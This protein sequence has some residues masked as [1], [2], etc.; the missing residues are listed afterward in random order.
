M[1]TYVGVY[2]PRRSLM[3]DNGLP[4]Y[5][6][7]AL[8][9]IV[10]A[11]QLVGKPV[12]YEHRGIEDACAMV[13]KEGSLY[14]STN[15]VRALERSSEAD[16]LR[17]PIGIID[18]AWEAHDGRWLC[19]FSIDAVALP[20]LSS[21]IRA[22]GLH[23]LSLSHLHG[24]MPQALEVSLCTTPA[25]PGCYVVAGPF[26]VP[27]QVYD[28]KALTQV[29][30]QLATM[31]QAIA[32]EPAS[33]PVT[34]EAALSGMTAE[35]RSLISAAFDDITSKLESTKTQNDTLTKKYDMIE[36]SAQIDK[37]LLSAQI[38]TF[39]SQLDESTKAQFNLN[40]ETCASA[41]V[42]EDDP[43]SMRRAVDRMLMCCNKELMNRQVVAG[44][45]PPNKRKRREETTTAVTPEVEAARPFEPATDTGSSPSNDLRNALQLFN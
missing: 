20:R 14:S 24:S 25:R 12:T 7:G 15:V 30:P 19:S 42:N 44:G 9:H 43:N 41:I 17:S 5:V 45:A 21:L 26:C 27:S 23:G 36:K 18:D 6:V 11:G 34:M 8:E 32:H 29:G 35:H 33:T 31:S 40:T 3:V 2:Y 4:G 37:K 13:A 10:V 22:K 16:V 39:L 38:D 28:Y 1:E